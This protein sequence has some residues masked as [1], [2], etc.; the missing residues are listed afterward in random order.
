MT[1][2][3]RLYELNINE[4]SFTGQEAFRIRRIPWE[5]QSGQKRK[6][7]RKEM[8]TCGKIT[9]REK[10]TALHLWRVREKPH[11]AAPAPLE[12]HAASFF[13]VTL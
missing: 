8:H 1:H 3:Q 9:D 7:Y 6:K 13:A 10:R 4:E 5:F 11:A 2:A 12:H